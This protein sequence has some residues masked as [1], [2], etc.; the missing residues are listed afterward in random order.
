MYSAADTTPKAPMQREQYL[1][2]DEFAFEKL[3]GM[4]KTS[5]ATKPKWKQT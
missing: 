1:G 4:D 2:D 5:F 3:F